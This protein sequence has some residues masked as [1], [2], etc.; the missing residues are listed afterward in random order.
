MHRRTNESAT[1][2]GAKENENENKT[3]VKTNDQSGGQE[4]EADKSLNNKM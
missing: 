3:A 4:E 2:I 1:A